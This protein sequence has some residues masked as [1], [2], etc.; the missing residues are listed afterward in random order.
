MLAYIDKRIIEIDPL[1]IEDL[2][3]DYGF[4]GIVLYLL[5]RLFTIHNQN[6]DNPFDNLYLANVY[7]RVKEIVDQRITTSN[8]IDIFLSFLRYQDNKNHIEKAVIYDACSFLNMK[9]ILI[10]DLEL[11]LKGGLAGVGLTLILDE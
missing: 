2:D 11:G 3:K 5:A 1:R 10:E 7:R 4:G 8:S 9:N 6:S